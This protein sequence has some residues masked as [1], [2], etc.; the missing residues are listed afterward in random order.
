MDLYPLD[1]LEFM[2]AMGYDDLVQLLKSQDFSLITNF[3][4]KYIDLLKQ[5]Y[6]IGGMPAV[7]ASFIEDSDYGKVRQLQQEILILNLY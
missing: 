1:F 7:V 2:I 4:G 5:Y 6:Y 3:K